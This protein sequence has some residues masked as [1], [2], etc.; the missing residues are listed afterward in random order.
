MATFAASETGLVVRSG[1]E[2]LQV[3]AWGESGIRVR[4]TLGAS[5]TETPWSA[6]LEDE[7]RTARVEI[8]DGRARV[9][10]GDLI[11]EVIENGEG[12]FVPFPPLLRFLAR[13]GR[14]SSPRAFRT[15]RPPRSAATARVGGD[16]YACDVM[17][18]ADPDERFYGLGQHQHGLLDQK[19]AVVELVQRNTEVSVPFALSSRGYGFL[20]NMPG[21]GRVEL[22]TN[23]TRWVARP[24]GRSTTG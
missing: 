16:L 6:L 21:V 13:T 20:W 10:N 19:G 14:S 22:A 24:P 11:V 4:A 9:S 18:D 3:D 7:A 15:S 17:F 8:G 1:G 12:R 23:G 5:V 2:V